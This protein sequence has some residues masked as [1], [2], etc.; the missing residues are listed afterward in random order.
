MTRYQSL[1]ASEFQRYYRLFGLQ[2]LETQSRPVQWVEVKK[3][4]RQLAQ[5]YHP[6]KSDNANAE[7]FHELNAAFA[8]LKRYYQTFNLLPDIDPLR[9][10]AAAESQSRSPRRQSPE[11]KNRSSTPVYRQWWVWPAVFVLL[12]IPPLVFL[13]VGSQS[14]ITPFSL[15]TK[16][17]MAELTKEEVAPL[18]AIGMDKDQVLAI[19]GRPMIMDQREWSYG[20][21]KVFF[22][23]GLVT[24]WYNARSRPLQTMPDTYGWVGTDYR[25][26]TE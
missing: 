20:V 16:K 6:D 21:S 19:Q 26:T 10:P 13:I 25:K 15:V 5:R 24:G 23:N 11:V 12:A 4:Y 14:D 1:S 22:T 9:A 17:S 3:A 18:I 7:R 2:Q 8:N